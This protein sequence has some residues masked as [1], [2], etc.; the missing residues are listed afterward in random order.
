MTFIFII[1]MSVKVAVRVHPFS[2]REKYLNSKLCVDMIG[3]TTRLYNQD[4]PEKNCE[5]VFDHCFWS[6]DQYN[7]EESGY[8]RYSCSELSPQSEKYAD[9]QY[10]FKTLGVEILNNAWEGYNCCLFAYGQTASG[11]TYSILG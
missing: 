8:F 5:F 3:N 11:K 4:A 9:Q 2:K 1:L 6:H 7:L 10:V